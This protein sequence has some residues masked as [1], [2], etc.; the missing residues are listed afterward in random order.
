[1]TRRPHYTGS[2]DV[3]RSGRYRARVR[4][5]GSRRT[6]GTYGTRDE[7]ERELDVY[8]EACLRDGAHPSS[9]VTLQALADQTLRHRRRE[10]Y[11]SVDDDESRWVQ[12][13]ATLGGVPAVD[14]TAGDVRHWLA[15]LAAR[16]L[17]TQTR[18]N[19]LNLLRAVL[20]HGVDSGALPANVA[21]DVAV[22]HHGA[23]HETSTH[24]TTG[25]AGRLVYETLMRN[26]EIALAIGSGLRAGEQRALRWEDVHDTHMVVRF[27]APGQPTKNGKVR[28]VPVLP[29]AR[30]ALDSSRILAPRSPWVSPGNDGARAVLPSRHMWE[31]ALKA[32]G[33][34]R[35]VRWHDLRHTCATLLLTGSPLLV[36]DARPWSL[37]AVRDMLGHSSLRI[38]ERY[39]VHASGTLAE[40]AARAAIGPREGAAEPLPKARRARKNRARVSEVRMGFEPTFD[41]FANLPD[42]CASEH[43]RALAAQAR[44]VVDAVAVRDPFAIQRALD[45]AAAIIELDQQASAA[46]PERESGT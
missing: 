31:P 39:T 41:G 8:L 22:R 18:R 15:E 9:G 21:T 35:W 2:V 30:L 43:L 45:L 3:L 16:G 20:R 11:R 5:G 34:T 36:P 24:L 14:L 26:P 12:Y 17:A 40:Q 19:A 27:G 46:A 6:I 33:I 25:E 1:M 37:E 23:T 44:A 29:L 7:A 13:L 28:R 42:V 10:G 4:H 32:A 38:T